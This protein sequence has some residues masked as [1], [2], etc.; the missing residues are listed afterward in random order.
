MISTIKQE[1]KYSASE[2]SNISFATLF[3]YTATL[4]HTTIISFKL[5]ENINIA[6]LKTTDVIDCADKV[7]GIYKSLGG[8][9]KI[10]KNSE[11]TVAMVN[12]LEKEFTHNKAPLE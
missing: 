7:L 9:D 11:F 12:S 5:L 1:E 8:T 3:Y 4:V 2:K 6:N 10:A